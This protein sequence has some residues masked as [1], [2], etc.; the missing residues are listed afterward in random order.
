MARHEITF[1]RVVYERPGMRDVP[2][3]RDIEYAQTDA[4]PLTMDLYAPPGSGSTEPSP[5]VVLVGGYRDVGVP[6][7]LGCTAKEMEMVI[8]WAQLIAVSGLVAIS[9]T[10]QD[11]ARDA[12]R[13]FEFVGAN[14][15]SLGVDANRIGVWA[16]SGNGPLA[17]SLLMNDAPVKVA[18]AVLCYAFT[19]DASDATAVAE[20][21]AAWHFAN[22][23]AGRTVADM[24]N[25]IPLFIARAGADSFRGLNTALDRFI[26]D[27]LARNL[28]LTIIN[29][30]LAPHAFDLFDDTDASR[31]IVELVLTFLRHH[32]RAQ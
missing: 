21:S 30:A 12:R 23:T 31:H 18:C 5:A 3:R 24:H 28:P 14:A 6:L 8:S 1:R 7:A 13:L 2:V 32:L 19:L 4:G 29:A 26:Q 25:D 16:A 22:P 17:L 10:R 27:A 15:D 11:P 20:A 9:Y